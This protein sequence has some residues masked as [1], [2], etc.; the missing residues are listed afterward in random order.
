[1][2]RQIINIS[3]DPDLKSKGQ[4]IARANL[5]S[6]SGWISTL[7]QQ[8]VET[9]P[10]NAGQQPVTGRVVKQAPLGIKQR[11]LEHA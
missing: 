1:M 9:Q 5:R 8:A 2:A 11:Q 10:L 7:I 4:A 6:F 3:I